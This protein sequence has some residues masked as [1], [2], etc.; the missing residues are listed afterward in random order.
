M[1]I[2]EHEGNVENTSRRRMFSTFFESYL[3]NTTQLIEGMVRKAAK[4]QRSNRQA[5]IYV[6]MSLTL[7]SYV[8]LIDYA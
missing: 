4:H 6:G 3:L 5:P 1:G 8:V 2:S 7:Y